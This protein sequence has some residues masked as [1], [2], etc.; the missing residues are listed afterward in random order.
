MHFGTCFSKPKQT[1]LVCLVPF[2][3]RKRKKCEK[4]EKLTLVLSMNGIVELDLMTSIMEI[5]A[6]AV[7]EISEV[8]AVVEDAVGDVAD[9]TMT[10]EGTEIVIQDGV[11]EVVV[12][13]VSV[14]LLNLS[15]AYSLTPNVNRILVD[16]VPAPHHG[17][18]VHP[19]DILHLLLLVLH[20]LTVGSHGRHLLLLLVTE[21]VVTKK[22][23][24]ARAH[25]WP[26]VVG[27]PRRPHLIP[28]VDPDLLAASTVEGGV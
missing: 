3:S 21:I 1:W 23:G 18:K 19:V 9:S 14:S 28:A 8:E 17:G 10:V 16:V 27:C 20:H 4:H 13:A 6:D 2:L 12:R 5:V 24:E 11:T 22:L 26:D 15:L 25:L 7:V